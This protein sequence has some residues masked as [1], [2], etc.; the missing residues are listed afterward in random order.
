MQRLPEVYKPT[1]DEKDAAAKWLEPYGYSIMRIS[2]ASWHWDA[3]RQAASFEYVPDVP[4]N[5][6]AENVVLECDS[7]PPLWLQK[8]TLAL[9]DPVFVATAERDKALAERDRARDLAVRFEQELAAILET[10]RD[11][12]GPAVRDAP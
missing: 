1:R 11:L 4:G 8:E 6:K 3:A 7:L 5:G 12:L 2:S 10:L 9:P